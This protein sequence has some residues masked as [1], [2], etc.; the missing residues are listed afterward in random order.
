MSFKSHLDSRPIGVL[1][2]DKEEKNWNKFQQHQAKRYVKH[3]GNLPENCNGC[4]AGLKW[5]LEED[6]QLINLI[7]SELVM[8]DLC[9]AFNRPSNGILGRLCRLGLL[10]WNETD[11]GCYYV[12]T[13]LVPKRIASK[14]KPEVLNLLI[15]RGWEK[16]TLG[17]YLAPDWWCE[18]KINYKGLQRLE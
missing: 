4:N 15:D 10:R 12:Y 7:S 13:V 6:L 18:L 5:R 2:M 17:Q 8:T 16:N 11:K 14:L 3:A 1:Q 9:V